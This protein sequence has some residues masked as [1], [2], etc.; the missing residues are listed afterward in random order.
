MTKRRDVR[1]GLADGFEPAPGPRVGP[2]GRLMFEPMPKERP[3][4]PRLCDAGPCLHYHRLVTQV[5]A[6]DP[7]PQLLPDRL[8]SDTPG[9]FEVQGKQFYKPPRSFHTEVHHYC[10]PTPGVESELGSVPVIECNLWRPRTELDDMLDRTAR[11]KFE[12]SERGIAFRQSVADWEA[13]RG[14]ELAEAAV[15]EAL[16]NQSLEAE[17]ERVAKVRAQVDAY[18]ISIFVDD[19][20]ASAHCVEIPELTARESFPAQTVEAIDRASRLAH[21]RVRELLFD[22]LN[23]LSEKGEPFPLPSAPIEGAP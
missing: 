19:E 2:D 4:H 13:G 9:V 16:V 7:H 11:E 10:Y 5:D 17:L 15:A 14:D 18:E 23:D 20:A 6:A 21:G 22:Y 8:P 1:E 3:P 12:A